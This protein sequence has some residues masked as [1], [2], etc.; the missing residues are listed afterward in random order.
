MPSMSV[1]S[2]LEKSK[3]LVKLVAEVGVD[4]LV[5]FKFSLPPVGVPSG[6]ESEL[7]LSN[8]ISAASSPF[9]F[10]LRQI[11]SAVF[12]L[13]VFFVRSFMAFAI[14]IFACPSNAPSC[15]G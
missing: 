2:K 12:L 6:V 14:E 1:G 5:S 7:E 8:N 15:K 13:R 10:G 11:P 9:L 3:P 4:V